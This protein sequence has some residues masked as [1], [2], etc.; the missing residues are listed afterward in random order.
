MS[1]QDL[2]Q[3]ARELLAAEYEAASYSNSAR[4]I[5]EQKILTED[6][7]TALRAIA[8]ALRQQP[9]PVDLE[10]FRLPVEAWKS[11]LDPNDDDESEAYDEAD[12]L[13]SIIDNAGKVEVHPDDAAVDRFAVAMKAKLADARAKGRGG[14]Q[15]DEPGMQ[16]RL[17][18][19]LRTHVEKGDPRDVA[20]FAMFLHQ[21]YESILPAHQP[22]P[23]LD[24][25]LPGMWSQSD[26]M[27]GATDA[28]D[29]AHR[30]VPAVDEA[31]RVDAERYRWLRE[32]WLDLGTATGIDTQGNYCVTEVFVGDIGYSPFANGT[33]DSAIDAARAHGV[34]S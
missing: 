15:G 13:L 8:A 4:R 18:D 16:Q 20:N 26:F 28:A 19:M 10:Q 6:D 30:P 2:E 22:A 9:A 14:W 1:A 29:N 27:G 7:D 34:Q 5:R 21:R 11:H 32:H 33:L 3:R 25:E 12:R 31:L 23:V 24:D 17:S